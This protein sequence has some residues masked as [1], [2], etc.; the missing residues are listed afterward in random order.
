[1]FELVDSQPSHMVSV[2]TLNLTPGK[3]TANYFLKYAKN[4]FNS[5]RGVL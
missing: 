3:Y 1:M 2:D 4:S 5:V